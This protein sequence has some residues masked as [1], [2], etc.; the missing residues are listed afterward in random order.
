MKITAT[1]FLK[2][3]ITTAE[4]FGFSGV[5]SFKNH[6][7]IQNAGKKTPHTASAQDRKLDNLYGILSNGL[8]HFTDNKLDALARPV[9]FYTVEKVPRTGET[10]IALHVFGVPKSIAEA[11]LIHTSQ[12]MLRDLGIES[13]SV[14]VNSLGDNDS[15]Q[16]YNRELTNFLRKRLTDLPVSTRELMKEHVRLALMDL[17]AQDHEFSYRSPNPL[18]YLSDPSRKH[19]REVIE[20][21][22]MSETPYEID[23]RLIGH[24]QC[25][26][27]AIFAIDLLDADNR[28]L[29][30]QPL[31]ITGGRYNH[32]VTNFLKQDIPASG[33]VIILKDKKLPARTPKATMPDKKLVHLVHLGFAPKILSLR[34]IDNL[35]AKG[36]VVAHDFTNDSLSAQLRS[37]E[38]A[39]ARYTIIVGQKEFVDGTVI[40][41]DM[42]ARTQENIPQSEL[43][44]RLKRSR[45]A[46]V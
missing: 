12:A 7:D 38:N 32:F 30:N 11:L 6:S 26:A 42:Q 37:A 29:D 9:S 21:L 24:H 44:T 39:G 5:E 27:D 22:D 31:S 35:R 25:Y 18:E 19:F 34:L 16:R 20:Y 36:I 17:I 1:D 15:A 4:H 40:L 43:V 23:P 33:A 13:Y 28:R 14:R 8:S 45:M 10:A 46:N 41:R 3:A 2:N